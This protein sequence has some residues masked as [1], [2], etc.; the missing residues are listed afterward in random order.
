MV[1]TADQQSGFSGFQIE[2]QKNVDVEK[3]AEHTDDKEENV[4]FRLAAAQNRQNGQAY[5]TAQ[6]QKWWNTV[7]IHYYLI[8]VAGS[9][10]LYIDDFKNL[11]DL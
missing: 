11:W 4:A 5:K 1:D 3:R 7:K 8:F 6:C 2:G 9:W 10:G